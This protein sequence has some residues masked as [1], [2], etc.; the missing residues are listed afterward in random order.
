MNLDQEGFILALRTDMRQLHMLSTRRQRRRRSPERLEYPDVFERISTLNH[1]PSRIAESRAMHH[2]ERV[3]IFSGWP[4]TK[5]ME[6][7]TS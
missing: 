1:P 5:G 4:A 3:R 7:T 2:T 6:E